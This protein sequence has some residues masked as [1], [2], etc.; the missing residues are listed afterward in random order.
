V[1]SALCTP[2][3]PPPHSCFL[4]PLSPQREPGIWVTSG[5]WM[6][7]GL[8][9]L[10]PTNPEFHLAFP[11][12]RPPPFGMAH[13]AGDGNVWNLVTVVSQKAPA[14]GP[15][16]YS[17]LEGRPLYRGSEQ[18]GFWRRGMGALPRARIP[19]GLWGV[20]WGCWM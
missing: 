8:W 3:N 2:L 13:A 16:L 10:H 15:K 20:G 12:S 4:F 1:V 14:G 6:E 7:P 9:A 17:S 19:P 18:P 5:P 11:G